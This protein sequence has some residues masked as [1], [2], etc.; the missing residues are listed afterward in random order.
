MVIATTTAMAIISLN[1]R[2]NTQAFDRNTKGRYGVIGIC[3]FLFHGELDDTN[4]RISGFPH[5]KALA[6][7]L[8]VT[9]YTSHN[10]M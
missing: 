8:Y 5:D 1:R 6:G 7:A 2:T 9:S 10:C 3:Q 4:P